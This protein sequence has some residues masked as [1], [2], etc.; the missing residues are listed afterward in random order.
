MK[1]LAILVTVAALALFMI[2]KVRRFLSVMVPPPRIHL[3]P[4]NATGAHARNLQRYT[5]ELES[6]GFVRLDT[7]RVDPMHGVTLTAF[8]HVG[9]SLCAVVYTHRVAGTFIDIVSK[10]EAGRS[11]TVTTAPAGKELDQPEGHEKVFDPHMPVERMIETALQRRPPAPYVSWYRE[12][13]ARLFEEA[14]AKEMDWRASR[15]GATLDEVRRHADAMGGNISEQN[16][17]KATRTLQKQYAESR[18]GLD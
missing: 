5:R 1:M 15:G 8:T 16:I 3:A 18:R 10:N 12:S 14:Y 11:F 4:I 7:Y 13:F 9:E 6:R 2:A 17:Q